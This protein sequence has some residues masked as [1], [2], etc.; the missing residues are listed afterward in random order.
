MFNE[1]AF[2]EDARKIHSLPDKILDVRREINKFI[3]YDK[4]LFSKALDDICNNIVGNTMFRFLIT[5]LPPGRRLRIIDIGPEQTRIGASLIGQDGSSYLDCTVYI[6]HNVY[7]SS[8]IGI[9][10]RQYYLSMR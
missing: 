10:E 7:N 2:L 4:T 5:K 3:D 8:G 9:P 1:E 6:N